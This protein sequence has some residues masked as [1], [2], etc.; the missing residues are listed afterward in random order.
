MPSLAQS[1]FAQL[2]WP[3][4]SSKLAVPG[5]VEIE[6]AKATEEREALAQKDRLFNSKPPALTPKGLRAIQA[7]PGGMSLPLLS[8]PPIAPGESPEPQSSKEEMMIFAPL[9]EQGM[10]VAKEIRKSGDKKAVKDLNLLLTQ[11]EGGNPDEALPAAQALITWY[12]NSPLGIAGVTEGTV[13]K[14]IKGKT[15]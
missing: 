13:A 2:G 12:K 6:K 4:A 15:Q 14:Q 3:Q 7:E 9:W 10:K 11:V 1:L 8:T 5:M